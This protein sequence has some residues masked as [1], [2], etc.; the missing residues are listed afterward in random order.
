MPA[1]G[2]LKEIEMKVERKYGDGLYIDMSSDL[3]VNY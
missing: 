1:S 3:N 2:A